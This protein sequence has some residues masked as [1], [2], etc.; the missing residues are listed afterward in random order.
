M[1]T[2]VKTAI[3]LTGFITRPS[4]MNLSN[5]TM[6][7]FRH[8]PA[9]TNPVTQRLENALPPSRVALHQS[10]SAGSFDA[11]PGWVVSLPYWKKFDII[12]NPV[13]SILLKHLSIPVGAFLILK[14]GIFGEHIPTSRPPIK[15]PR[16][17]KNPLPRRNQLLLR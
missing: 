5:I 11:P 10:I 8:V 6:F 13:H 14:F 7:G 15:H 2:L 3:N 12:T 16:E 4:W 1:P 17:S 9:D